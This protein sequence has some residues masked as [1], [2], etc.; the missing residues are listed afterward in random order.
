M[1]ICPLWFQTGIQPFTTQIPT[2]NAAADS[3]EYTLKMC[4]T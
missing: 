1:T 2:A 3:S 4:E